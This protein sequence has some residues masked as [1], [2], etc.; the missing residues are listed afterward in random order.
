[1]T[2]TVNFPASLQPIAGVTM[3]VREPVSTVDE[4]VAALDRL[5]PGLAA[6]ID[7]PLYNIAVNNDLLLHNVGR[8]PVKDGDVLEIVPTLAGG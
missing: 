8:Q 7:D 6:A 1:M 2:V 5:K 3:L 4:V